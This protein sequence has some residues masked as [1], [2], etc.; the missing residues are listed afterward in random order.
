MLIYKVCSLP[1]LTLTKYSAFADTGVKGVLDAQT[2]FIR[3]LKGIAEI[4]NVHIHFLY[5]YDPGR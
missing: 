1:D 3:Q 2:Q 4:G 5:D